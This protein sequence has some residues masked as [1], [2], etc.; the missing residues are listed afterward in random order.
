MHGLLPE[1][2][3]VGGDVL[4]LRYRSQGIGQFFTVVVYYPIETYFTWVRHCHTCVARV[5]IVILGAGVIVVTLRV[6]S[7]SI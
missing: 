4:P 6:V 5:V 2:L 3:G 7:V 1:R